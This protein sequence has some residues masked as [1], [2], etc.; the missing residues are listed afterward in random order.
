[1]SESG[2]QL[3]PPPVLA[4][5][6]NQSKLGYYGELGSGENARVRFLQTAV[7]SGEL[8]KITLIQ[9]IPGSHKWDVRDLFQRDVDGERV[10]R[11]ILPYLQDPHRVKY[12][13]PLT[14]VLLPLGERQEKV[15]AE[16]KPPKRKTISRNGARYESYEW[17]GL[18][19][20]EEHCIEPAYSVVR[21]N[22]RRA[23]LVAIDG[24]HRLSALKR[25]KQSPDGPG[26]LADWHI[27]VVILGMF[28]EDPEKPSATM[29]EIVRKTFVYIN[30]RAEQVNRSRAILLD[31]ESI[32]KMCVQEMVQES[33][34]NDTK[35]PEQ[36]DPK[37]LPLMLFDWRG[38]TRRGAPVK[39]PASVISTVELKEWFEEYLIG[40]DGDEKQRARL[41][42][43][44]MIPPL[45]AQDLTQLV[46]HQDA[47]R[48][49][50]Q[51]RKTMYP[52][53]SHVLENF[54]PFRKYTK[55]LRRLESEVSKDSD[56]A[57]HAFQKLRFGTFGADDSLVDDVQAKYNELTETL[58]DIRNEILPPLVRRDIGMRAVM[59]AFDL[60]KDHRDTLSGRTVPW[61]DYGTWFVRG[62]NE[63]YAQGWFD[64]FDG[65]KEDHRRVLT[66]LVF[67]PSGQIIN[68]KVR[69]ASAAFGPA[70]GLVLL[71][72]SEGAD[73]AEA[74]WDEAASSMR[75][76]LRRG[77]R[78]VI[79]AEL[80]DTFQGTNEAFKREVNRRADEA[81]N[82]H[83]E[84]FGS[85]LGVSDT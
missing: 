2:E 34:S 61:S 70:L 47:A 29:L 32:V 10:T 58:I 35:G 5:D 46:S 52:G 20:F 40:P 54:E 72:A 3:T 17:P 7:T 82:G 12:F 83:L 71:K 76:P 73:A 60:L 23:K 80:R 15:L 62:L 6:L 26:A 48:I 63:V 30:S 81:V 18:F 50:E 66:H 33:H 75:I 67:D 38:E 74:F 65:Q 22:D 8:D 24:Q 37:K 14:L 31:D 43:R 64:D 27:P 45:N 49:R 19:A 57:K 41:Q 9:N 68:Y 11:D 42:T 53:L 56:L 1:M 55:E 28:L 4:G 36:R 21:W 39:A 59:S 69:D 77:F 78:K 84:F 16:L 25:W 13:N 44:D 79:R 51:F 85:V